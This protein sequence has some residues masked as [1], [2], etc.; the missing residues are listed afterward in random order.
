MPP[1]RDLVDFT[2]A[3]KLKSSIGQYARDA[4][5]LL[6][7]IDETKSNHSPILDS[8]DFLKYSPWPLGETKRQVMLTASRG[9]K[10][11]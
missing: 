2:F 11:T 9:G 4:K 1:S 10:I 7:I 6:K 5:A 3:R 8:L